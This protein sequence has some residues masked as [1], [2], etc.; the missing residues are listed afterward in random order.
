MGIATQAF[1]RSD[2][3]RPSPLP[4]QRGSKAASTATGGSSS[5]EELKV[6]HSLV[7]EANFKPAIDSERF[8]RFQDLH[9]AHLIQ[10][11]CWAQGDVLFDR[12]WE[13]HV[14]DRHPGHVETA[15]SEEQRRGLAPGRCEPLSIRGKTI[16]VDTTDF[17]RVDY[18]QILASISAATG[19]A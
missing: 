14:S 18:P 5:D 13:R 19:K 2:S 6:G 16:E 7:V 1:L 15:T 11:L 4:S 17:S 10:V 8:R 9:H 12:Y 3:G